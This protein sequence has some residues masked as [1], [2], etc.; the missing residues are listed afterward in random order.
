MNGMHELHDAYGV[1]GLIADANPL[2]SI[3]KMGMSGGAST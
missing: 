1:V 3:D 2:G